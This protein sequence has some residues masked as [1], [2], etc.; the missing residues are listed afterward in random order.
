MNSA[1]ASI[2]NLLSSVPILN[3]FSMDQT[4][5]LALAVLALGAGSVWF[6]LW[7]SELSKPHNSRRNR[8]F[9]LWIIMHATVAALVLRTLMAS[10]Q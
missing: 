6:T 10:Y 9:I 4:A 2:Q 7:V 1:M 5:M 3:K 8:Y